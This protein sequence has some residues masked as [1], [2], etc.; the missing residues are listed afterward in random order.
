MSQSKIQPETNTF[1]ST[2]ILSSIV[3]KYNVIGFQTV[4]NNRMIALKN[5]QVILAAVLFIKKLGFVSPG[6]IK[7]YVSI[8][9][10][11]IK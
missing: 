1:E 3:K 4:I 2:I 6:W 8:M 11:K 9:Q 10:S 5:P 7:I